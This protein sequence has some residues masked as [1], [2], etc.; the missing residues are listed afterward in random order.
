[1]KQ[2]GWGVEKRKYAVGA[3]G[4]QTCTG[5]K[6]KPFRTALYS[7]GNANFLK[8]EGIFRDGADVALVHGAHEH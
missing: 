6:T 5:L 3:K 7:V 4:T 8:F 2:R 1:M